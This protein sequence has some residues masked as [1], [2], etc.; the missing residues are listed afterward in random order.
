[1]VKEIFELAR[2]KALAFSQRALAVAPKHMRRWIEI[3]SGAHPLQQ[4]ALCTMENFFALPPGEQ[5]WWDPLVQSHPFAGVVLKKKNRE[6][7]N[8]LGSKAMTLEQFDHIC[9]AAAAIASV[10]KVY[11]FGA[12]AIIPWLANSGLPIPLPEFEP[13]R[14]LDISVGDEK[15]DTLI[16]GAIGELSAFDETFFVY[17]HGVSLSV[18]QA[19]RNWLER[20][21][22]R[23]ECSALGGASN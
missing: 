13:S 21:G 17:A 2:S 5:A 6:A 14:E 1:M 12:N 19:P 4:R 8:T 10:Q 3:I 9:R 22:K 11:V 15:L 20:A 16:D 18:F 7:S 23:T